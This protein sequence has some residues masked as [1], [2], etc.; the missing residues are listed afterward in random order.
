[1]LGFSTHTFYAYYKLYLEF[2]GPNEGSRY[3]QSKLVIPKSETEYRISMVPH[4][5]VSGHSSV[6]SVQS[7]RSLH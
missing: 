7:L 4:P 1:M 6:L 3:H 5:I 2:D